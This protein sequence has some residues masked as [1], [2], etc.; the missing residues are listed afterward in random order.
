MVY[1]TLTNVSFTNIY[2]ELEFV[3]TESERHTGLIVMINKRSN[4][5]YAVS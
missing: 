4:Y 5:F 2:K 3:T 1:L